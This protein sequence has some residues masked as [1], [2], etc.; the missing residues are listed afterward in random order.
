MVGEETRPSTSAAL[1]PLRRTTSALAPIVRAPVAIPRQLVST[2]AD[3]RSIAIDVHVMAL[4][5][6]VLPE[7]LGQLAAIEQRV[8]SL[9]DEVKRMRAAVDAIGAEVPPMREAVE[10]LQHELAGVR[11][12]IAPLAGAAQRLGRITGRFP[13]R[14]R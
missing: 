6:R 11:G 12:S 10:P 13:R 2:L 3:V 7:V 1:A 5:T 8:D 4:N 9:D 14:T